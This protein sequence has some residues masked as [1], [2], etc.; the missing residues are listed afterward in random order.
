MRFASV[1]RAEQ[2][3][4]GRCRSHRPRWCRRSSRGSEAVAPTQDGSGQLETASD[5]KLTLKL[6]PGNYN[7]SV[8][9]AGFKTFSKR[10]TVREADEIQAL[11]VGLQIAD[12]GSPEVYPDAAI[13]PSSTDLVL[14]TRIPEFSLNEETI[15][16]GLKRLASGP[17]PF[18]L[19]FEHEL[20]SKPTDPPI[21]DPRLTLRLTA[22]TVREAIDTMCHADGRYTWS[23]DDTFINVYPIKTISD[24][25]Y[26]MN[27]R[28]V[29]LDLKELIDIQQGLLA[30]VNQ[31]PPPREQ[32]AI[33]QIG[34]DDTYPPE[35]WTT[36]Y[37][38][39]T[40]RQA[41]NRLVR[42]MGERS[43]WAF[44]GS[45]DFRAFAFNK[46]GF[47]FDSYN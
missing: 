29:K 15:E 37:E 27:R 3:C 4:N 41:I 20:K 44:T 45:A 47:F 14:G 40:V 46:Q 17:A 12:T 30:I 26:L 23:T 18:A 24:A 31:L 28:L 39:L 42:H 32:V 1:P 11:S 38:N 9:C 33:A 34:A 13:I 16:T 35:L 43:S 22:T 36:S 21:Q 19:G 2:A 6:K 8:S 10:F 7:L 5:G 25:S